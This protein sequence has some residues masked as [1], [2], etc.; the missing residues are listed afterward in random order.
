MSVHQAKKMT[1]AQLRA[2]KEQ[3]ERDF[4]E[5]RRLIDEVYEAL[6]PSSMKA[7]THE[8]RHDQMNAFLVQATELTSC[9]DFTPR[10]PSTAAFFY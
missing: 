1:V 8:A 6:N 5:G 3:R 4:D 10:P 2:E 9:F 7:M